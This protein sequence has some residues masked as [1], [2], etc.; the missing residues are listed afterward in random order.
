MN[1]GG[2]KM[3]KPLII[4][5]M[6]VTLIFCLLT[7]CSSNSEEQ[8]GSSGG[9]AVSS[10]TYTDEEICKIASD[11]YYKLNGERPPLAA[12]DSSD[13]NIVTVRLYEDMGDHIAT[14]AWYEL[15]LNDMTGKDTVIGKTFDLVY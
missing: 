6:I 11:T 1:N 12:V 14:W 10:G 4:S 2:D 15:N 9:K 13:G 8:G 7:G 3:R 5:V